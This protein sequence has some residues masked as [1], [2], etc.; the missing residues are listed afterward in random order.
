MINILFGLFLYFDTKKISKS[1]FMRMES[2]KI[3]ISNNLELKHYFHN[4][5][6]DLLSGFLGDVHFI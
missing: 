4:V 6:A 5:S 3:D 1:L 2:P